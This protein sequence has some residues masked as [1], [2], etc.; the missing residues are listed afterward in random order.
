MI[1]F[2]LCDL[3]VGW[4]EC[5]RSDLC[6][7][8]IP[9]QESQCVGLF[10]CWWCQVWSLFKDPL[11]IWLGKW[12]K[13]YS[14]AISKV[15]ILIWVNCYILHTCITYTPFGEQVKTKWACLLNTGEVLNRT[16]LHHSTYTYFKG[17]Y[18]SLIILKFCI[19]CI[20]TVLYDTVFCNL[21]KEAF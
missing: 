13:F 1:G 20:Q 5:H 21:S 2:S 3:G 15:H 18:F 14:V 19:V 4:Q 12:E 8:G 16:D 11:K 10:H 17:F 9:H 7:L 6:L